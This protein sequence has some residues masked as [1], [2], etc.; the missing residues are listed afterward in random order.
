VAD[1]IGA[2]VNR[3]PTLKILAL[4]FLLLIGMALL[5]DG[6][7]LHIP[8]GYIYFTMAFAVFVELLNLRI[9]HP[10]TEPVHLRQSYREE[11]AKG[12]GDGDA[13]TTRRSR[14]PIERPV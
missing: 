8:K 6:F 1:A 9:R 7:A 2:F 3:H 5:A 4:S 14:E 10:Q 11:T 13:A 12:M